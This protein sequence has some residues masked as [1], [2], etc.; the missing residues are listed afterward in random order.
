MGVPCSQF[1]PYIPAVTRRSFRLRFRRELSAFDCPDFLSK[2]ANELNVFPADLQ[3]HDAFSGDTTR[4]MGQ[5]RSDGTSLTRALD[6]T[7]TVETSTTVADTTLFQRLAAGQLRFLPNDIMVEGVDQNGNLVRAAGSVG[8][9]PIWV[10]VVACVCGLLLLAAVVVVV[11]L[12]MRKRE[13]DGRAH[14]SSLRDDSF[15]DYGNDRFEPIHASSKPVAVPLNSV[16][17]SLL[18]ANVLHSVT[19]P[20]ESALRVQQGS[21]AFI[22]PAD[23]NDGGEWVWCKVGVESGYIPRSYLQLRP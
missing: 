2:L 3:M 21:I 23:W 6:G 4:G 1:F 15:N 17:G 11:I 13:R 7:S 22:E 20:A 8:G 16:G 14:Y 5:S 19:E 9:V 18:S 10:I 12:V